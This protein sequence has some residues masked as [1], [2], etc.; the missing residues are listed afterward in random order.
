[1]SEQTY[2]HGHL[3]A[4]GDAAIDDDGVFNEVR[5]VLADTGNIR[6]QGDER[7]DA[8]A[9]RDARLNANGIACQSRGI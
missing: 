3:Q 4:Q 2:Q 5:G 8:E 1:L 7:G 9:I 6:K